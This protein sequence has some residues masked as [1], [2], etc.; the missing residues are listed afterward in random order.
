MALGSRKL[1]GLRAEVEI[2]RLED[3]AQALVRPRESDSCCQSRRCLD[4][5]RRVFAAMPGSIR[6]DGA[7]CWSWVGSPCVV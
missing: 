6:P 4:H 1:R 5:D 2:Y 7:P 3:A